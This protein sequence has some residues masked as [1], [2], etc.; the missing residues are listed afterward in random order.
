M[1][2][3]REAVPCY[4]KHTPMEQE[5]RFCTAEDG[6]RIAYS[7]VG[8]GP[9]LV[10]TANWLNHLEFDWESPIWRH[11]FE[12]FG[13]DHLLVRYDARGNGLSDWDAEDLS[14]EAFGKDL[15]TVV[16]T[17][18]LARFALLGISQ[19]CAVSIAYAVRYPER[20]TQLV[21]YGGYALGWRARAN[22]EE[23]ARREAMLTLVKQGWGQD[24]PAFRRCLH[25]FFYRTGRP[26]RCN[27]STIC[28]ASPLLPKTPP[29]C[30]ES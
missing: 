7:K 6:V 20:V 10:K 28:S 11:L 4:G 30:R 2:S 21:L 9:P 5:I 25:R 27:G 22:P 15:E 26:S 13:R 19:G 24:N 29:D 17:V 8:Q 23:I 12:E 3:C 14:F 18:G 16:E 1:R